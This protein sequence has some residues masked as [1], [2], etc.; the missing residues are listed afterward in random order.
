MRVQCFWITVQ[1]TTTTRRVA[2][3]STHAI[4]TGERGRVFLTIGAAVNV[5]ACVPG[6]GSEIVGI[7]L[8]SQTHGFC[9]GGTAIRPGETDFILVRAD[10]ETWSDVVARV[11]LLAPGSLLTVWVVHRHRHAHPV[12]VL[13]DVAVSTTGNSTDIVEAGHTAIARRRRS[14]NARPGSMATIALRY[15]PAGA[16]I[17]FDAKGGRIV[18]AIAGDARVEPEALERAI[19]RAARADTRGRRGGDAVAIRKALKRRRTRRSTPRAVPRSARRSVRRKASTSS[20][21]CGRA[22]PADGPPPRR[23]RATRAT[24]AVPWRS[25]RRDRPSTT[26]CAS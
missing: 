20:S 3:K 13:V 18:H 21:L 19:V 22:G 5:M 4:P 2:A 15:V 6:D 12:E 1:A 14:A 11:G 16:S 7:T 17:T 8:R 9:R 23:P 26:E 10:G 24:S 25:P